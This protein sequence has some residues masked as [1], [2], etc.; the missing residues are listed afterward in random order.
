MKAK[1]DWRFNM[2]KY[3]SYQSNHDIM[4]MMRYFNF[5]Q[6]MSDVFPTI[7]CV[8]PRN[9]VFFYSPFLWH[10]LCSLYRPWGNCILVN[11]TRYSFVIFHSAKL[12]R[13]ALRILRKPVFGI[14]RIKLMLILMYYSLRFAMIVTPCQTKLKTK[15]LLKLF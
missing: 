1:L 8:F 11:N 12:I 14:F 15:L 4:K 7:V 6:L 10:V 2:R 3:N 5:G 9:A 13:M